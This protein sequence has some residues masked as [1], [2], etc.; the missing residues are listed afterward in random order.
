MA[1]LSDKVDATRLTVDNVT[2]NK[3]LK[4][5][6]VGSARSDAHEGEQL[7]SADDHDT[8]SDIVKPARATESDRV[9]LKLDGATADFVKAMN[10][11]KAG[12][13]SDSE[14][15]FNHFT[16][17]FPEHILAGSAQ[18]FA[19]ESYF[20][21]GEYKL[22]INEYGKVISSFSSSPRVPSAMVRL[23]HCYEETG[24]AGEA[25]RTLALAHDLYEGNPSLD[26][27]VPAK[28]TTTTE[29]PHGEKRTLRADLKAAPM[30][31]EAH[32]K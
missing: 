1:A 20:M 9:P 26:W 11:F 28:Q 3:P 10:L 5:E 30:E 27:A 2:G 22:A 7:A 31:P 4:V 18:F 25:S 29:K 6:A 19:G 21:M 8:K 15:A 32:H 16:E 13:Y 12:K 17:T 14:L 24:N 23:A